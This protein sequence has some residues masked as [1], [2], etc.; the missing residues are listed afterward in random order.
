MKA[1]NVK[2][3]TEAERAYVGAMLDGEGW[4]AMTSGGGPYISIGNTEVEIIAALL[5]ATGAGTVYYSPPPAHRGNLDSYRWSVVR[6]NEARD[7]ARQVQEYSQKAQ[8]LLTENWRVRQADGSR[9]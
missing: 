4:V 3:M 2:A 9:K 8:R 7:I 5:R 1:S 6:I